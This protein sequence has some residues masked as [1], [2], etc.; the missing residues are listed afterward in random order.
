MK[1]NFGTKF[2]CQYMYKKK[3]ATVDLGMIMNACKPVLALAQVV[4]PTL[5]Q[6]SWRSE[7]RPPPG[8]YIYRYAKWL[9]MSNQTNAELHRNT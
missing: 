4:A 9:K 3:E 2:G 6:R 1:M 8:T 5:L 7:A